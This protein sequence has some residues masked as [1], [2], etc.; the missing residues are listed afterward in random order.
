MLR[1][2]FRAQK[3]VMDYIPPFH[4]WI[5]RAEPPCF[6]VCFCK[7]ARKCRKVSHSVMFLEVLKV[8]SLFSAPLNKV[9]HC[10]SQGAGVGVSPLSDK[11]AEK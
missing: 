7:S 10:P 4:T 6:P 3:V 8:T 5:F 2:L 11:T 9:K 1:P